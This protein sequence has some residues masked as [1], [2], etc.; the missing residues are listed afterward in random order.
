M[1][2]LLFTAPVK[3]MDLHLETF[4]AHFEAFCA[5]S[6]I[7]IAPDHLLVEKLISGL[8]QQKE[9]ESVVAQI[10]DARAQKKE[11]SEPLGVF[12][13]R[14]VVDPVSGR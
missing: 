3:N 4:S 2:D 5:D 6:F 7:A 14:Y 8:P 12:T 9:V 13:G 11:S 1:K 10:L